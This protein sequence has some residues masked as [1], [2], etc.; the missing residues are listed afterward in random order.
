MNNSFQSASD[1]PNASQFHLPDPRYA[2]H[3]EA[4]QVSRT[5]TKIAEQSRDLAQ[6]ARDAATLSAEHAARQTEVLSAMRK[7]S[8]EL[9]AERRVSAAREDIQQGFNRRMS[10]AAILLA[11][12]AVTVPFI[13]LLIEQVTSS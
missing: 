9:A 4:M 11:G 5:Q 13:V 2:E 1:L 7:L 10:W 12:A 8:E 3:R 6:E